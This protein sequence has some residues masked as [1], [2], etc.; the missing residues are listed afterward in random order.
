MSLF[1]LYNTNMAPDI[2][3]DNYLCSYTDLQHTTT[4]DWISE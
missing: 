3:Q 4:T 1:E 2:D